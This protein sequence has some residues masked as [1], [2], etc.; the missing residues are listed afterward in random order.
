MLSKTILDEMNG[1]L[2]IQLTLDRQIFPLDRDKWYITIPLQNQLC[3]PKKG[4]SRTLSCD[5]Q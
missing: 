1:S 5:R 4:L 3:P 2:G